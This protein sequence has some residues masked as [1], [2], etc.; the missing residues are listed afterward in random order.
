MSDLLL[1]EDASG[2]LTLED[3]T[4]RLQLETTIQLTQVT[5]ATRGNTAI[6][7]GTRGSIRID[8]DN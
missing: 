4:G 7:A 1:L 6:A 2:H 3:A 5:I 8:A